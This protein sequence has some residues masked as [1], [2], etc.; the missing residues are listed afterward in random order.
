MR[1]LSFEITEEMLYYYAPT[2]KFYS[3]VWNKQNNMGFMFMNNILA[4]AVS[5]LRNEYEIENLV[6]SAQLK[7]FEPSKT[8][9]LKEFSN[10]ISDLLEF[11][12]YDRCMPLMGK[13]E[14]TT[15]KNFDASICTFIQEC[16]P[17]N[18]QH[19]FFGTQYF[20]GGLRTREIIDGKRNIYYRENLF[21]SEE[22]W[23]WF[24]EKM[25]RWYPCCR[26]QE[27]TDIPSR[28]PN[29]VRKLN[30]GFL[31]PL[32]D[33]LVRDVISKSRKAYLGSRRSNRK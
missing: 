26:Y 9:T 5:I 25:D 4:T 22:S 31:R 17:D 6:A 30:P 19:H 14:K 33:S 24:S 21:S 20:G 16:C 28:S 3:G 8:I 11:L 32:P 29:F 15:K 7:N 2:D 1:F 18:K 23:N 27:N 10:F 13:K 12:G